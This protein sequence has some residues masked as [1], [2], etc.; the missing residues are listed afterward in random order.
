MF[1]L[2]SVDLSKIRY[3]LCTLSK[4]SVI[5]RAFAGL[6]GLEDA[7][8]RRRPTWCA[9]RWLAGS[10]HLGSFGAVRAILLANQSE[11]VRWSAARGR[12]GWV[13]TLRCPST[14]LSAG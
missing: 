14:D 3:G 6:D 4:L 11:G 8:A 2:S 5:L 12:P 10:R 1:R 7:L 9:A 13:G